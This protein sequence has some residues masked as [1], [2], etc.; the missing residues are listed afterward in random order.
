MQITVTPQEGV[1]HHGPVNRMKYRGWPWENGKGKPQPAKDEDQMDSLREGMGT[2]HPR[3]GPEGGNDW[4][5]TCKAKDWRQNDDRD[6]KRTN[7]ETEIKDRKIRLYGRHMI[8][9]IRSLLGKLYKR[10]SIRDS[11]RPTSS[12]H[13]DQEGENSSRERN[14]DRS[15]E[16][17]SKDGKNEEYPE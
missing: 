7:S 15:H 1:R 11:D 16:L 3:T 14:H 10:R 13:R 6:P 2:P 17:S 12:N 8:T 9:W 5:T 4:R